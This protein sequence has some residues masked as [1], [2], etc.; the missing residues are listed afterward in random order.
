MAATVD[1]LKCDSFELEYARFGEGRQNLVIIPGMGVKSALLSADVIAARY[2]A[3]RDLCTVYVLDRKSSFGP[4]YSIFEMAD[5]TAAS[6]ER[7]GVSD[8]FVFGTSM[9]GMISLTLAAR[10]P[11]LVRKLAVSSTSARPNPVLTE[12]MTLWEDLALKGD[13]V[14]LNRD[15]FSKVYSPEFQER[16]KAAL[17]RLENM[18]TDGELERFGI[19]ARSVRE[20]D[21]YDELDRVSCPVLVTGVEDDTV[22]SGQGAEDLASK[23][24]CTVRIYKGKGHAIYDEDS[25]Y[26]EVL[27]EFFFG[28]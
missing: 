22:L 12:N 23:L 25:D 21:I 14:A 11:S 8:A 7:L 18:G 1:T 4:G 16:Y 5:D 17:R 9:G 28:D 10:Y 13:R 15:V 2:S 27:K 6:L 3:F 24:D 19:M 26:P 20:F